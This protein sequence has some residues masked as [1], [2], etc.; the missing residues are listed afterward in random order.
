[1]ERKCSFTCIT[2]TFSKSSSGGGFRVPSHSSSGPAELN[3]EKSIKVAEISLSTPNFPGTG[4][5]RPTIYTANRQP[6]MF[7]LRRLPEVASQ[8]NALAHRARLEGWP[9]EAKV[10]SQGRRHASPPASF[11]IDASPSQ[12]KLYKDVGMASIDGGS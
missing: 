9:H 1:M 5:L 6:L 4:V 3:R 10:R 11:L 8:A 2:S 12:M 7:Q